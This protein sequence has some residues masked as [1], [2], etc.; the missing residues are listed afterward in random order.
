LGESRERGSATP[1]RRRRNARAVNFREPARFD[2][3]SINEALDLV[4]AL[5]VCRELALAII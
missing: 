1:R 4:V 2:F 5:L 3:L